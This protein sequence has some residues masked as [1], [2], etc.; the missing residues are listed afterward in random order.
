MLIRG[1]GLKLSGEEYITNDDKCIGALVDILDENSLK[2]AK[3]AVAEAISKNIS[4][5]NADFGR[6]YFNETNPRS[7][8]FISGLRI[9]KNRS[10]D[11]EFT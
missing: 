11:N 8:I 2:E 7:A 1:N 10:Q 9:V 6:A 4:L 5:C 3:E